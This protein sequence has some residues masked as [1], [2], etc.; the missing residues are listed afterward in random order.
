MSEKWHK[1]VKHYLPTVPI[2]L[3]GTKVDMRDSKQE[4]PN[5]ETTEYVTTKEVKII[6]IVVFVLFAFGRKKAFFFF[7]PLFLI[8]VIVVTSEKFSMVESFLTIS[9]LPFFLPPGRR[10]CRRN[11]R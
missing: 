1:E 6:I 2:I 7:Y 10:P 3:V 8:V 9:F 11:W 4:D 5:A